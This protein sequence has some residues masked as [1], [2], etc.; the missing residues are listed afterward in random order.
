[1]ILDYETIISR[2]TSSTNLPKVEIEQKVR[3]KLIDYQDLISKEG[4]AHMIANEFN[5]KLFDNSNKIL[6]I[7]QKNSTNSLNVEFPF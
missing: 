3:Q 7:K 2:I 4:A 6:K 1:M 5:V